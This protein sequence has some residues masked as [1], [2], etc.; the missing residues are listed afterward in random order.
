[1]M[2]TR[3][4]LFYYAASPVAV[5]YFAFRSLTK[6]KYRQSAGGMLGF[7]LPKGAE[8]ERFRNGSIWI[9]AVSVGETVAARSVA[10]LLRKLAPELPLVVTT[11]TETGQ[12]HA[13]K[14]LSNA[15]RIHY[16]PVDFSWNVER[17]LQCFNPR[18]FVMME[19]ELWPNF[20]TLAARSG[21]QVF[22]ANGKISDKSFR[23]YRRGRFL[24][25]P[26][27]DA[28]RAFC[29]QT[30]A[31]AERMK[32]LSGRP[33]DVHVTGNCKFDAP[34]PALSPE[35]AQGARD[36]YR[37]GPEDRPRLVVGSTHPGE[38]AIVL[39]AFAE[40]RR[41][42]PDL[43]M[44][45]SPRHPERFQEVVSLCRNHAAGWRV[46]RATNPKIESPDILVL[47]T[48]GEL[49]RIYALG[50]VAVVAGSFS[51]TVGGHNLLEPAAHAV[52][53]VVGP[54]MWGQK[55]IDRLF[56]G[57][58]SGCVRTGADAASLASALLD[59]LQNADKCRTI[60]Q[61]ALATA[62]RNQGSAERT[63][64]VIRTYLENAC[65]PSR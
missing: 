37:L 55:E 44:I 22:M 13:R 34:A 56:E 53:V 3:F 10:P 11:I 28:V 19:T 48:M 16:F 46:S 15:D 62:R 54:H 64:R 35:A 60:G 41:A 5:P 39:D 4:D 40:V 23:G 63:V 12:A 27:F 2:P 14:I 59:L 7:T 47:D 32:A 51:A 26:A 29:M 18:L 25:R 24:L 21:A 6:G 20:L 31:D 50:R 42:I 8:R 65:R 36:Q 17:F 45:L 1:M 49:A 30:E 58:D 33:R 9:H 52:P 57:P 43:Q 38:E 61:Q